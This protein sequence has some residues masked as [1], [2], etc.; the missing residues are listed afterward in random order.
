M[1]D[2][3]LLAA[4]D[5]ELLPLADAKAHVSVEADDD[6][7]DAEIA[8]YVAAAVGHLDGYAGIL[9]R[10]LAQ[11]S[12]RLYLDAFPA[13]TLGLPLPPLISVQSVKYLDSTDGTLRALDPTL[14]LVMAGERA[15]LTP[16]FGQVW[17]IARYQ[18]RAVTIDFTCG[19][20][21]PTG[22]DPWPSKLQPVIAALKLMTGDLYQNRETA[23]LDGRTAEIPMSATVERLLRPLRVPRF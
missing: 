18:A 1:L 2:L 15:E 11:Q 4:P 19:W 21:A 16:A 7:Q 10:A 8:A 22:G 5:A 6:S 14:Y 9:G 12:W 17:P 3:E 13:W 20:P 23:I